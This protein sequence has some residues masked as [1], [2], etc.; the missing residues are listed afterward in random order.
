LQ[1]LP[2]VHER[3]RVGVRGRHLGNVGLAYRL[4]MDEC[5]PRPAAR[6]AGRHLTL[7]TERDESLRA[8]E[9]FERAFAAGA[10][11]FRNHVVGF[12]SGSLQVDVHWHG[13]ARIWGLFVRQPRDQSKKP[14]DRFWNGFGVADPNQEPSLSI[15]VE[16]TGARPA[17]SFAMSRG[18][19]TSGI[20]EGSGVAG[21]ASA[22]RR[23]ANL[24]RNFRGNKSRR[25]K[26]PATLST[27]VRSRI[28][29]CCSKDLP[30]T[31]IPWQSDTVCNHRS[32][33]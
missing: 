5:E 21:P 6:I 22:S 28:Q 4:S 10:A 9:A 11:L 25:H 1:P 17:S 16:R 3:R 23:S 27:L 24:P 7:V 26:A 29:R 18:A 32:G 13:L 2:C 20:Q 33:V 30:A 19:Y 14:L 15:T 8:F 12:R 31:S